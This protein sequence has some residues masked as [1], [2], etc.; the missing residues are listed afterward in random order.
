MK[1]LCILTLALISNSLFAGTIEPYF[2]CF[3]I[4]DGD[5]TY[6]VAIANNDGPGLSLNLV[7]TDYDSNKNTLIVSKQVFEN[8]RR[9]KT[10]YNDR[11]DTIKL[12]L[13]TRTFADD[14]RVGG[15]EA[16]HATLSF[17][18]QALE[19]RVG[20]WKISMTCVNRSHPSSQDLNYDSV[21]VLL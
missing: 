15:A 4:D 20:N 5:K 18:S 9:G 14:Y 19:N 8:V 16:R 13:N 6:Q 17:I 12:E 2:L 10:T 21:D 11:W 3:G 7:E 1:K